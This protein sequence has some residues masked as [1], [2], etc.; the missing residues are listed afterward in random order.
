MGLSKYPG[1]RLRSIF[2]RNT[3]PNSMVGTVIRMIPHSSLLMLE[4][5]VN[6]TAS[7]GAHGPAGKYLATARINRLRVTPP[8][9][10]VLRAIGLVLRLFGNYPGITFRGIGGTHACDAAVVG[11]IQSPKEG[12]P[13]PVWHHFFAAH[14]PA[15]GKPF[16]SNRRYSVNNATIRLERCPSS[17]RFSGCS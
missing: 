4:M 12:G 7:F 16:S 5:L 1:S 15:Y 11:F 13:S 8:T 14:G 17:R 10:G 9:Q 3:P 6:I 2:R